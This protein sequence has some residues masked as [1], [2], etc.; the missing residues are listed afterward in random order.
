M[1][2][3][4]TM[5]VRRLFHNARLAT[6]APD[7]PGLGLVDRGAV[8][9]V[10]GRIVF[11]GPSGDLGAIDAAERIDCEGRLLTPGLIDCHT[12]LVFG[13][14]RAGEFEQR[15]AGASYEDIARAGG[16]IVSSVRATREASKDAL[17]EAA[18]PR[19]DALIA[20]GVTTIEVKS[21]YGLD[22]V[23][24]AK[25]LAA[26]RPLGERRDVTGWAPA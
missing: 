22:A 16:G 21:G 19:L 11:A 20:E 3:H 4:L 14:H 8:A 24:E 26:G 13:G 17:V 25:Q 5:R 2:C 15:L 23:N 18:L 7:Q 9:E 6:L 1:E 10:D 12:H